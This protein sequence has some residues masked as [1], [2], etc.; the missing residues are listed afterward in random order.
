MEER[1][2]ESRV[3]LAAVVSLANDKPK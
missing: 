2:L 3:V 1:R